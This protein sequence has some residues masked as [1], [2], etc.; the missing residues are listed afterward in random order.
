MSSTLRSS[1]SQSSR[2]AT[3]N[4]EAAESIPNLANFAW[5]SMRSADSFKLL[6]RYAMP[7]SRISDSVGFDF[8]QELA[9]IE[10][11]CRVSDETPEERTFS[12]V[13]RLPH[14][15]NFSGV[16]ARTP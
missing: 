7:Q 13:M 4:T 2:S 9:S 8:T 15:C 16:I 12:R 1:P 5:G 14:Q 3:R 10:L 11:A 6:A